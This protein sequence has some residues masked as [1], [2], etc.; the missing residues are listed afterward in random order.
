MESRERSPFTL[1]LLAAVVLIVATGEGLGTRHS[2]AQ[3]RASHPSVRSSVDQTVLAP[4]VSGQA[5]GCKPEENCAPQ[6]RT[7][8]TVGSSG[9]A[10]TFRRLTLD[11]GLSQSSI[12]CIAQDAQGFMWFGTQDGL[13][14][15]DGYEFEVYRHEPG[16]NHSLSNNFVVGCETDQR[17]VLW[18]VTRDG[19]LHRYEPEAGHFVR[20][21]L[22][23]EDP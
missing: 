1:S 15:Y 10:I 14:R 12:N 18:I 6:T 11:D 22:A 4:R 2:H 17:D 21:T 19:T 23:L 16:D 20:Y 8:S 9:R 13:N 5:H 7:T 3:V